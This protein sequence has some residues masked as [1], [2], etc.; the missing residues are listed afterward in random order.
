MSVN[1]QE[2][3]EKY[4]YVNDGKGKNFRVKESEVQDFIKNYNEKQ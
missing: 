3:K 2:T 4:V 1:K